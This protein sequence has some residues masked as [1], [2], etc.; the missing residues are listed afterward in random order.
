MERGVQGESESRFRISI[1]FDLWHVHFHV[2]NNPNNFLLL[3]GFPKRL[4]PEDGS[5][6][7]DEPNSTSFI[8]TKHA[9]LVTA[10]CIYAGYPHT[11]K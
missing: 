10:V 2:L 11:K 7:V 4:K 6:Y 3:E 5:S 8:Y 9:T 1:A